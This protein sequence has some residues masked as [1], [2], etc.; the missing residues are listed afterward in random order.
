MSDKNPEWSVECAVLG[1]VNR[2][3]QGN[4]NGPIC[5]PCWNMITSGKIANGQ[6]FIHHLKTERDAFE[7]RVIKVVGLINSIE[8]AL[9]DL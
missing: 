9:E 3:N 7:S 5:T 2:S 1:C 6:T 8:D 4:F